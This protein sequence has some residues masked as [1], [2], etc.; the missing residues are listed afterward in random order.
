MQLKISGLKI[1]NEDII[2][3]FRNNMR[4]ELEKID[5]QQ[6][7]EDMEIRNFY[8]SS[9]VVDTY[10]NSKELE[11]NINFEQYARAFMEE[12]K[13]YIDKKPYE[14][15]IFLSI[16]PLTKTTKKHL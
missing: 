4:A 10:L 15:Y 6:I 14:K 7:T 1:S 2:K 8:I 5:N 12:M 16:I 11:F 13:I 9:F 3:I